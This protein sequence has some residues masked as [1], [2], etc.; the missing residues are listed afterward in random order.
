MKQV[1]FMVTGGSTSETSF[2]LTNLTQL[3]STVTPS[4]PRL[5]QQPTG[6]AERMAPLVW[7]VEDIPFGNPFDP[8]EE[9]CDLIVSYIPDGN[10]VKETESVTEELYPGAWVQDYERRLINEREVLNPQGAPHWLIR[11]RPRQAG[12]VKWRIQRWQQG[13]TRVVASG[14]L[15]VNQSDH[16]GYIQRHP[17]KPT[18][19][20]H[21]NGDL[22]WPIGHNICQPVDLQQ[23]YNYEFEVP[24]D[25]RTF[26]YDR[27]FDRMA[28]AQMDWG[29][30]WL[31]PWSFGIEGNPD[32]PPFHGLNVYNLE[33]AWRLRYLVDQAEQHGIYLRMTINHKA[34][35]QKKNWAF[36]PYNEDNGGPFSRPRNLFSN[37][38][39]RAYARRMRYLIGLVGDS[40]TIDAW[41]LFGEVNLVPDYRRV[42]DNATQ[43]HR[44]LA[45]QIKAIDWQRHLVM[46]HCH[47]W[48][49]GHNLWALDELDSVQGNGYIRYPNKTPDHIINFR[50]YLSEVEQYQKPVFVAE[51]GGRS[52]LGAPDGDYLLAQLHSGLWAS[53]VTNIGGIAKQ[54]WWNFTDGGNHYHHYIGIRTFHQGMDRVRFDYQMIDLPTNNANLRASALQGNDQSEHRLE[55]WLHDRDIFESWN[56][57]TKT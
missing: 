53:M 23:P 31:S 28:G 22:F 13:E 39:R 6:P 37:E 14:Q 44:D 51:Y 7:R 40:L 10:N 25:Q 8:R 32:W 38:G 47:N 17:Q 21:E 30:I 12:T 18:L 24:P 57:P 48:Q 42:K 2:H 20:A 1:G 49:A 16:P 5:V 41:E 55:I 33:N 50:R 35:W 54:W 9:R 52:E 46:S 56:E 3:S 36:N 4:E 26:T 15:N 11:W 27:F 43:W 34:E 19:L 45:A 29:R